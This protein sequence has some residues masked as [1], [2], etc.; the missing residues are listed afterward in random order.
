MG[1][2]VVRV[3]LDTHALLWALADDERLSPSA[4]EVIVDE[5]N[6]VLVSVVSAWEIAVK[7]ALGRLE[8]PDNLQSVVAEAGFL[9]RLVLFG[10]CKRLSKLPPIHRDPFDRMLVCQALEE[11]IPVVTLDP[12]IA[13]YPVQTIW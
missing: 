2:T 10:D 11:G 13:S 3:L 8:A 9:Q 4:R 7:R 12:M 5:T 6:D 1:G